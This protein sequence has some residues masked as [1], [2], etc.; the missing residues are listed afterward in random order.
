MR[1][2]T[3]FILLNAVLVVAFLVIFLT[4]LLL[5]GGDWF[6]V[7]WGRNWFIGGVFVAVLAAVDCYFILNWKL[8]A[9]LENENWAAVAS[10][11]EKRI[12]RRGPVLGARVRLLLNTYLVTSN[13][14]GIRALEKHFGQSRPSLIGRFSLAFGIPHLLAKEPRDAEAFFRALLASRRLA[15]RDWIA[16][17]HAFSLM[18]MKSEPEARAELVALAD[19]VSEPVLLLLVA[20]LLDAVAAREPAAQRKVAGLRDRLARGR[21]PEAFQRSIEKASG[22]MQVVVLSRL[23]Q[24]AVKWLFAPAAPARAFP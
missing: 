17:D 7:F 10:F 18:Q 20:Y 2:K 4:P 8:F 22:N 6:G 23:V 5:L 14:E 11:L 9:A 12:Y 21:S 15:A 1:M 3:I 16:W 13:T 19:R 24:D